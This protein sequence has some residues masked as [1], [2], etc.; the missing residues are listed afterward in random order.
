MLRMRSRFAEIHLTICHGVC[1]AAHLAPRSIA[2]AGCRAGPKPSDSE[3]HPTDHR[4][5]AGAAL[6]QLS[7]GA[8]PSGLEQPQ[9]ARLLLISTLFQPVR[10][11]WVWLTRSNAGVAS[12]SAPRASI[13]IRS[14][15]RSRS[16]LRP[17]GCAGSAR[18]C[19]RLFAGR[20]GSGDYRF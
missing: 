13:A 17:A 18:C 7:P 1:A 19:W 11:C 3:Q 2:I 5:A 12:G 10:S 9:A 16:S 20:S 8:E 4:I 14:A 6:R 15:R